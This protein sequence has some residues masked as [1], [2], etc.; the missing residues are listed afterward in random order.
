[1]FASR[2]GTHPRIAPTLALLACA[3][4][5]IVGCPSTPSSNHAPIADDDTITTPVDTPVEVTLDAHDADGD[6]LT[7][8]IETDPGHG[9][10]A[11]TGGTRTY[12]PDEGFAGTDSFTFAAHDASST[13]NLATVTLHVV[14]G[15]HPPVAHPQAVAT[16]QDTPVSITLTGSDPDGDELVFDV[17]VLPAHGQ[18]DGTAPLLTYA[19]APGYSGWDEFGFTVSDGALTSG[20][21]YV[22]VHIGSVNEAPTGLLLHPSPLVIPENLLAGA[23]VGTFETIDADIPDGDTHAYTLVAGDGD[24][25]NGDFTISGDTLYTATVFDYEAATSTSIRVR[26]TD[27]AGAFF[28]ERFTIAIDDEDEPPDLAPLPHRTILIGASIDVPLT[29]QDEMPDQLFLEALTSAPSI[30]APYDLTILGTSSPWTLRITPSPCI[31]GTATITVTATD[32]AA[33]SDAE[34]FDLRIHKPFQDPP[35]RLTAS[36]G[37]TDDLFGHAVA[38]D[39]D[40]ALVGAPWDSDDAALAGAVYAFQR[41]DSGWVQQA[42]LTPSDGAANQGFGRPVAIDGDYAIVGALGDDDNGSSAGAA[43]VLHRTSSGWSEGPKLTA[44]DGAAQDL[45][46][47]SVALDGAYALIGAYRDDDRGT[48]AGAA[49]LFHRT[50]SGWTELPKLTASD[51]VAYAYFGQAVAIDGDYAIV[52]AHGDG[53]YVGAAYVF[54]RTS[55]GWTE[56]AKLTAS[57][58]VAPDA[59]GTSVAIDSEYAVVGCA[60][61]LGGIDEGAAYVFHRTGSGWTELPKLSASDAA[62]GDEFGASVAID[63][64]YLLVGAPNHDVNGA[65]RAGAAYVFQRCGDVWKETAI[66][67]SDHPTSDAQYGLSVALSAGDALVGAQQDDVSGPQSNEGAAYLHTR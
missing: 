47:A 35:T 58:G 33:Q 43:Y 28:E 59:F 56:L 66:L 48:D 20:R 44:S 62:Q 39:G 41:T 27:G 24:D 15:N 10:L 26:T 46:G 51:G 50:S 25:G 5:L 65:A 54:Q 12:T 14:E 60:C 53:G 9:T 19:P 36:D 2:P 67:A 7:F 40:T 16:D 23:D 1:M 6:A 49:Y 22:A 38:I 57:D 4:L 31:A 34:T 52:G 64:D 11:G 13:S 3:A 61:D 32:P 8:T 45:F 21:A 18:L 37:G 30:V 42:K 63:G 55:S 17:D 29:V